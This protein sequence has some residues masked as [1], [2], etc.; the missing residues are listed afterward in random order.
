MKDRNFWEEKI[1]TNTCLFLNGCRD[2]AVLIYK[3]TVNGNK[4]K[5]LTINFVLIVI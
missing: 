3:F 1:H 2:T 5:L 4:E